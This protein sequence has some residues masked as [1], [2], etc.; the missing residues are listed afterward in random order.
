MINPPVG[1]HIVY[2][3][4]D[5]DRVVD[6]VTLFAAE[7]LRKGDAVVLVITD[8]HCKKVLK[9]LERQHLDVN[10]LKKSDRLICADAT[11]LLSSFMVDN[12]PDETLFN[13][14]IGPILDRAQA[15]IAGKRDNSV[16]AFGEMVSLLLGGN[17]P[18]AL[19]L[20]ELWNEIVKAR[21]MCLLCT[22]CLEGKNIASLPDSLVN[23]HSHFMA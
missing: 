18:A 7:G 14:V 2:P 19:K 12:S 20:E 22:Y 21:S 13:N 11:E 10:S 9:N 8:P 16:R 4:T 23:A 5:G 6:A 3:Y 17:T 15:S 1:S